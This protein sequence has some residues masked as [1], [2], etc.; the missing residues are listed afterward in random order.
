MLILHSSER[1]Q[2]VQIG[3]NMG[4]FNE[5]SIVLILFPMYRGNLFDFLQFDNAVFLSAFRCKGCFHICCPIQINIPIKCSIR[6]RCY[7]IYKLIDNI[8]ADSATT[9]IN[10][11]VQSGTDTLYIQSFRIAFFLWNF[12]KCFLK[13]LDFFIDR[14]SHC[15]ILVLGNLSIS[16]HSNQVISQVHRLC[17]YAS[18]SLMTVICNFFAFIKVS[19]LHFGQ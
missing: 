18:G 15:L 10:K 5:M 16:S 14:T 17:V 1:L 4:V 2:P 19:F 13:F 8:V 3:K 6:C 12:I 7:Q 9:K 11:A